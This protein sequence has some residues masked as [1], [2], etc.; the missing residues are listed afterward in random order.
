MKWSMSLLMLALVCVSA[1]AAEDDDFPPEHLEELLKRADRGEPLA[2]EQLRLIEKF[3]KKRLARVPGNALEDAGFSLAQLQ[4]KAERGEKALETLQKLAASTKSDDVKSAATYNIGKVYW[5]VLSNKKSA[6]EAF[7]KVTGRFA[8]RA[9]RDLLRMYQEGG[10]AGKAIEYLQAAVNAT[11]NK[12]EK[13][14][15][16]Q[17]L[18]QLC[19]QAGKTED[20]IA[21]YRQI[22]ENFTQDD[23][24]EMRKVAAK[25]VRTVFD[26]CLELQRADRWREAE[27]LLHKTKLWLGQL[28]EA[29]RQDE[30]QA[31]R[32]EMH[33][34][35]QRIEQQERKQHAKGEREE[36]AERERDD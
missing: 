34:G 5:V 24:V 23:I 30:F 22:T 16:L 32:E 14:A 4:V 26:K 31:A 7:T 2:P 29:G 20:A 28:A 3:A 15:L 11:K 33:Q 18:A 1:Y 8:H 12:G 35:W 13:L 21:A 9:R 19:K 27:K 6:A 17:Q 36:E 25:R 10:Q